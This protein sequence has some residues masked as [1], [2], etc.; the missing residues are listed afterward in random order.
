MSAIHNN[1]HINCSKFIDATL[2]IQSQSDNCKDAKAT[3]EE[4]KPLIIEQFKKEKKI[5]Y[6]IQDKFISLSLKHKKPP[7]NQEFLTKLF[8]EFHVT[9]VAGENVTNLED[10]SSLFGQYAVNVQKQ[11]KSTQEDL[12]ITKCKP[13]S[14]EV[15]ERC[16]NQN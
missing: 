4:V 12:C 13:R 8:R 10:I 5:Y 3:K 9:N 11:L 14:A 16:M 6:Q 2:E 1:L 15:L 7:F